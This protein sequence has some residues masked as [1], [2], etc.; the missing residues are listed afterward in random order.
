[1]RIH[2]QSGSVATASSSRISDR[3]PHDW[4]R[5]DI[6]LAT[7]GVA[8][9]HRLSRCPHPSLSIVNRIAHLRTLPM[10]SSTDTGPPDPS[11]GHSG[12]NLNAFFGPGRPS[13]RSSTLSATCL[14]DHRS[15]APRATHLVGP[16]LVAPEQLAKVCGAPHVRPAR[17]TNPDGHSSQRARGGNP[18]GASGPRGRR[19]GL[20]RPPVGR[21][22]RPRHSG[23][24]PTQL[25]APTG[26]RRVR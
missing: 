12:W 13:P 14:P 19:W 25:A 22:H 4:Q 6:P 7:R 2:R 3:P 5:Q 8:R 24:R 21:S 10:L 17:A 15:V 16:D 1:M 18:A 11:N 20:A 9:H 26:P 23:A